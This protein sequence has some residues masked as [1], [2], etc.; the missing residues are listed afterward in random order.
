MRLL[1]RSALVLLVSL[2]LSGC[3]TPQ[4]TIVP[5]APKPETIIRAS[6]SG[7]AL[8]FVQKLAEAYQRDHPQTR[9]QIDGGTNSGG[10]ITGVLEGTL[11]IGAVNRP[12][13]ETEARQLDYRAFARDALAF[14]AHAP[15][16]AQGVT[17]NQL[18]DLYGGSLTNWRELGG[19]AAPIIVLDRD[20]EEVQRKLVLLKLLDGRD[21]QARTTVFTKAG[22]MVL[23]LKDTSASLGYSPLGLLRLAAS[24]EIQVLTLDGIAPGGPAV[25]QGQYP[26]Y[27]TYGLVFSTDSSPA[28]RDF[29]T[30][31]ASPSARQVLDKYDLAPPG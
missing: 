19:N 2:A 28:V 24:P 27:L 22:D 6:G 16:P 8:P 17:T 20:T 30:Y 9:F 3:A 18:R 25:E 12:L 7:A 11:D 21:V 29:A 26:W 5:S 1:L 13:D 15:S 4:P 14:A 23:G 31:A 10:G